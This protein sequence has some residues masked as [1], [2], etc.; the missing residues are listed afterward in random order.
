VPSD[1]LQDA[2]DLVERVVTLRIESTIERLA[3][4]LGPRSEALGRQ[5]ADPLDLVDRAEV[6]EQDDRAAC[7]SRMR[8]IEP[9][10][11]SRS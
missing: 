9:S 4:G 2:H 11:R 7:P 10:A 3:H 5:V 1:V 8:S 6:R